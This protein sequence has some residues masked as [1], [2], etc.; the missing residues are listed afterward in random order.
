MFK[1]KILMYYFYQLSQTQL[2]VGDNQIR[3]KYLN[4]QTNKEYY[5]INK[6]VFR[7]FGK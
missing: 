5:F 2:F 6:S 4:K 1:N 3:G 7:L